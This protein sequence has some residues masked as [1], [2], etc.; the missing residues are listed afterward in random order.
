MAHI[1]IGQRWSEELERGQKQKEASVTRTVVVRLRVDS[2]VSLGFTCVVF[3][4]TVDHSSLK[5]NRLSFTH[6]NSGEGSGLHV[7]WVG[8]S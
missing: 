1:F 2:D 5:L 3:E 7:K 8:H 6:W 4:A